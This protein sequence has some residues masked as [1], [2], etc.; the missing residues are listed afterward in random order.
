MTNRKVFT[1]GLAFI[2][3]PD[4]FQILGG[5]GSTGVLT[6]TSPHART[7]GY[8][9]LQ[10]G[11]PVH[12]TLGP[13]YGLEALYALFGW[14]EGTFEFFEQPVRM[15]RTIRHSRMQIIL[16]ALRM[17]D[18]GLIPK[19][20][21]P[22]QQGSSPGRHSR[23]QY[24]NSGAPPLI[25]GPRIDYSY[26]IGEEEVRDGE[27][28][29]TE[30]KHGNWIWVILEGAVNISR[31]TPSGPVTVTRLGEG[32]F[33]GTFTSFLF[34]GCP[35][36]ANVTAVGDVFLA[37]VD[38]ERISG[39]YRCL[40]PNFRKL[41]MSLT[42]RLNR[43][44]NRF[45]DWSSGEAKPQGTAPRNTCVIEEGAPANKLYAITQGETLLVSKTS[46]GAVPLFTL[47][48]NDLF[49]SLPFLDLG[50]EPRSASVLASKNLMV[51][52]VNTKIL[53]IEYKQLCLTFKNLIDHMGTC[54]SVTTK[55]AREYLSG[56]PK[57]KVA[58]Q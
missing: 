6:I 36:T 53:E 10:K 33:I 49:G 35:R 21:P 44:T 43:I 1:G 30:G 55:V 3:L 4:I 23:V 18:D 38:T 16:D 39:E 29:V 14:M 13:V 40:S 48:Q 25:N 46:Q 8:V 5:N 47:G 12:A 58:L 7:C 17:L 45:L 20:G 26:I 41:L 50:Q 52:E 34:N 22:S 37:L 31:N 9:Y 54:V 57:E 27:R 32:A 42:S 15:N 51:S 19:L 24:D 56:G 2:N 11:D 28:F